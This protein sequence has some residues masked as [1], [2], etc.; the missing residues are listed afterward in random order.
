MDYRMTKVAVLVDLSF[1]LMQ[2]GR[3]RE[4]YPI[5]A[6]QMAKEIRSTALAHLNRNTDQ[7][8]RIFVYDCKPLP[9]KV[10]HPITRRSVDFSRSET[11]IFRT[12]L[13]GELVRMRKIALRLGE[14]ADRRR[15]R[16]RAEVT[17][18]LLDGSLQLAEMQE[19]DVVYDVEQKGVDTK[20]A[21]D[22]ASLAYK[23]LVDRIVLI[24]G[25]SDFIPAAKL[26]RREGIEVILDPLWANIAPSFSEHIDGLR[27]VWPRN[28]AEVT[29]LSA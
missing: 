10:H 21:I 24:T 12:E 22:I 17:R 8:Y 16:I 29:S 2:Y 18:R 26:A 3:L 25:D 13:L 9:K 4:P 7:L 15:W 1:F 23:R 27:S 28:V 20:L 14:L 11:F 6:A 5:P 19:R